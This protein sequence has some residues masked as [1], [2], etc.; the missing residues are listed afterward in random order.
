MGSGP[1][2]TASPWKGIVYAI[3][4]VV[5]LVTYSYCQ[6]RI[7][8]RPFVVKGEERLFTETGFLVLANRLSA[9]AA[10]AVMLVAFDGVRALA[11]Q[12][13]IDRFPLVS[14]ANLLATTC[15][16]EAL[17]WISLP[18]Q[19]LLK[20]A[21]L[22]PVMVLST[23]LSKRTYTTIDYS[24][25]VLVG[26]GTAS[27]MNGN[28]TSRVADQG[29]S[30]IGLVLMFGNIF[31]DSLLMAYQERL[32]LGYRLSSNSQMLYVNLF[33]GLLSLLSCI[34]GGALRS[35]L[36]LLSSSRQFA[37]ELCLLTLGAV[38]A[39][40]FITSTIKEFGAVFFGTVITV[41]QVASVMVSSFVIGTKLSPWQ[42][43]SCGIVF[44]ALS[45]RNLSKWIH[46]LRSRRKQAQR[47]PEISQVDDQQHGK[48]SVVVG[49]SERD[50]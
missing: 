5:S 35:S 21:K 42:W 15:Q 10:A 23:L 39:Q 2:V 50:D 40:F 36:S 24:S 25:A 3:G 4:I 46:A 48:Q 45:A 28:I 26:L 17:K 22:I 14:V 7:M 20:C 11:P 16:Y 37:R 44:T 1:V 19:A 27:F 12:A 30:W 47:G 18:T 13:P 38:S 9:A 29:N 41:Q 43:F 49:I 6:E 34:P 32:F 33:S 8:T 31:F